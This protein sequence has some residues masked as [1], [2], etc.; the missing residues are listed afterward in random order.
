M[1]DF[2][3]FVLDFFENL[4]NRDTRK[5]S[6]YALLVVV[7]LMIAITLGYCLYVVTVRYA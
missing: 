3:L 6:L 5:E 7:A 4:T 1:L 2:L